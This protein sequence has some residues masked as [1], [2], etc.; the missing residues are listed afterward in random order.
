[1]D[2][3]GLTKNGGTNIPKKSIVLTNNST[4]KG[5]PK[6]STT[7]TPNYGTNPEKKITMKD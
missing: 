7:A 2:K 3:Y 1:M 4:T 6:G 5:I